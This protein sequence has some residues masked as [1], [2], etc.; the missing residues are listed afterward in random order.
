MQTNTN[1]IFHIARIFF[2]LFS[3][4]VTHAAVAGGGYFSL[5]YGPI[6]RQMAGAVTAVAEDAF[7]GSSNPAKLSAVSDRFE[8]GAELF[9]PHRKVERTGSGTPFDFSSDS[10]NSLFLIPEFAYAHRMNDQLSL[11]VTVYANGGLNSEYNDS[12]GVPNT[13]NNPAQ[14]GATPGNFFGGCYEAGF[15]LAQLIVAPTAAWKIAPG[16]S[17]GISPLLTL[18]RFKSFGLQAFAPTSLYPD[19][20]T[21]RGFDYA[22]GGGVRIGWYGEINS[23]LNLGAAYSSKIYMQDFDKYKGLFA[24]GSFDI[25][26]NYSLG[27]AIKPVAGW[28][29]AFD[30]QRINFGD[31]K[32]LSNS[33]LNTLNNPVSNPLGSASGSGFGWRHNQTNFK[34]GV[35][36]AASPKLTLRTGF[37][38]GKKPYD[39]DINAVSFSI[40]TPSP[41]RQASVGFS[42]KTDQGDEFHM[43][44]SRFYKGTYQ[45][46]SALFPGATE[47][48]TPYVNT[49]SAA[50]S[51]H[52]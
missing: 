50:W 26:S 35:A 3:L 19:K 51:W 17:I 4:L 49:L 38:Y 42:W 2:A 20:V 44:A 6:A 34:L 41:F 31:V 36:Y 46:P 43:A 7:A 30:V 29:V 37:V 52:L 12:T 40:L 32:A 23:W 18:E 27:V 45:G 5:G 48:V 1:A 14:C 21:N 10:K 8:A 24:E 11:G 39:N 16:Y 13:N 28:L 15:D 22:F 47:S 9:N 25:P 33:L